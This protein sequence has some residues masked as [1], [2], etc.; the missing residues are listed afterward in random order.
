MQFEARTTADA[1]LA[2]H[3]ATGY[4]TAQSPVYELFGAV[5][6]SE[7]KWRFQDGSAISV[8]DLDRMRAQ[9]RLAEIDSTIDQL[10]EA[11]LDPL[12]EALQEADWR[13]KEALDKLPER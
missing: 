10:R 5:Q 13:I 9:T 6:E 3:R 8:D 11:A 7:R 1:L 12:R 4:Y 2:W